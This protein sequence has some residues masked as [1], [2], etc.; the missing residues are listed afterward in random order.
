MRDIFP[1]NQLAV[2]TKSDITR[3]QQ[4]EA[5]TRVLVEAG[6][7][8]ERIVPCSDED[9]G[10]LTRLE[11]LSYEMLPEAYRDAFNA[12]QILNLDRKK[13]RAQWL[14]QSAAS[15]AA[16]VGA[17]PI[18][19]PDSAIITP[20]QLGMV[21][22]LAVLYGEPKE[23]L[24]AALMPAISQSVGVQSAA[25]LAKLLPGLGSGII[26]GVAFALTLTVG[27]LA[28]RHLLR[29]FE[30]RVAG[31]PP[32]EFSFDLRDFMEL[33]RRAYTERKGKA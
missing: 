14:I 6:V 16:G 31:R 4:R 28:N 17:V 19:F 1:R 27:Q 25:S 11:D 32:P 33:L 9:R 7:P 3:P 23:G 8:A 13:A 12:A 26:A 30:A 15:A 24:K 18:P 22:S 2:L 20:V 5:M 10:S 29:R 21:A